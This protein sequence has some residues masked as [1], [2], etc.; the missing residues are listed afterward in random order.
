RDARAF[1]DLGNTISIPA[2]G[3]L[4]TRLLHERSM[5]SVRSRPADVSAACP[6]VCVRLSPS[7][8]ACRI[9]RSRHRR[10]R[11]GGVP[12]VTRVAMSCHASLILGPARLLV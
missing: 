12:T 7:S 10:R 6:V 11:C 5:L 1:S 2:Y 9:L 3:L 8:A 4:V